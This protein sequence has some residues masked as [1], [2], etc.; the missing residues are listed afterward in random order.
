MKASEFVEKIKQ[1]IEKHGDLPVRIDDDVL[2]NLRFKKD[3]P[4]AKESSKDTKGKT[5]LQII[6][7]NKF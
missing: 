7:G 1:A 2:K 4:Y 3:G 6:N 5:F